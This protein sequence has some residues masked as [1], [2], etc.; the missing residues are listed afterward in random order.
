[1][2]DHDDFHVYESHAIMKYICDIKK[3]PDHWYPT[4]VSQH[5]TEAEADIQVRA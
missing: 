3:L 4:S 5:R 2:E 1:M